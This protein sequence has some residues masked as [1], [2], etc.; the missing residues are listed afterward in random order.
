MAQSDRPAPIS[1]LDP[2]WL[3]LLGG[4]ALIAATILIPAIRDLDDVRHQRD[5][6]LALEQHR[7]ERLRRYG[8]YLAALERREPALVMALAASQLNKIPQG[9]TL[10]LESFDPSSPSA[11]VFPALEPPPPALP[12]R[13]HPDSVLYSWTTSERARPWLLA[14]GGVCML[15]GL[16]SRGDPE[17]HPLMTQT[18]SIGSPGV[19]A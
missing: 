1:Y 8:D 6:A 18:A 2:G 5:R 10:I 7:L 16:M 12:E 11:S 15:M 9:R 4:I 17:R 19:L 3:Y 14:A 13:R